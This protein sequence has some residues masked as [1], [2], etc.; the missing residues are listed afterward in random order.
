MIESLNASVGS[1]LLDKERP[2][3]RCL[4]E[5]TSNKIWAFVDFSSAEP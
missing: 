3:I 4:A 2:A 1:R 5:N